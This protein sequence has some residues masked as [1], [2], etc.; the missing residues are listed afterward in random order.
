MHANSDNLVAAGEIDPGHRHCL[1][2]HPGREW[3]G[4]ILFD[5]GEEPASLL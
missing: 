5:H 2:K 4:E 1:P 3:Q